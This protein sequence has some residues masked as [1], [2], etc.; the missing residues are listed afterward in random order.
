MY[1]FSYP[2]THSLLC[3][4]I[5]L[6]TLFSKLILFLFRV[7]DQLSG[8]VVAGNVVVLYIFILESFNRRQKM[9]SEESEENSHYAA[10]LNLPGI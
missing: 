6:S 4:N 2:R 5:L 7:R 1:F 9:G 3:S 10:S 8:I